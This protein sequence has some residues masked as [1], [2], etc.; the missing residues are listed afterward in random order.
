MGRARNGRF[1]CQYAVTQLATHPHPVQPRAT[2]AVQLLGGA[3]AGSCSPC[4]VAARL[5]IQR[6]FSMVTSGMVTVLWDCRN[7]WD[8]VL[9]RQLYAAL[10]IGGAT[11]NTKHQHAQNISPL[12]SVWQVFLNTKYRQRALIVFDTMLVFHINIRAVVFDQF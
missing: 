11:V 4:P 2:K 12:Q 6:C 10:S 3:H 1:A 9:P 7:V 5:S 8:F